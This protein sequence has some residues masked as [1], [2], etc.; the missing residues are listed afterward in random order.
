M[1]TLLA[2]PIYVVTLVS[3]FWLGE[4]ALA[5]L[6]LTSGERLSLWEHSN[7]HSN[8]TLTSRDVFF[9]LPQQK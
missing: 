4:M 2:L 7:R 3:V 6:V 1:E 8:S 9:F 5:R